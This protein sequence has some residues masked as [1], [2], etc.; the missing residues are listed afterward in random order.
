MKQLILMALAASLLVACSKTESATDGDESTGIIRAT[1]AIEG[2]TSRALA[3]MDEVLRNITFVRHDDPDTDK[4]THFDFTAT[5]AISGVRAAGGAI[6]FSPSQQYDKAGDRTAYLVGC[7]PA[8]NLSGGVMSWTI[9]GATDILLTD[10]WNAGRHSLTR[11]TGMTFRHILARI[12]VVCKAESG[13]ALSVVHAMWGDIEYIK[14]AGVQSA[15]TYTYA[16]HTLD[17]AGTPIDFA[18]L[19]GDA[20][21]EAFAPLPIPAKGSTAVTASAMLPPVATTALTFKVK[22]ALKT[23]K[24]IALALS[25]N[26]APS[27]VHRVELTF[28]ANGRDIDVSTSTIEQW[29]PGGTGGN[30]IID[31]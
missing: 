26:F 10:V 29:T 4:T 9:D 22:N 31:K 8:G 19:R 25:S 11:T 5:P 23:E 18:L 12:E 30:D 2:V 24:T 6:T 20:Y 17:T 13:S 15:M 27:Q 7:H 28:K 1:A 3:G 16:T 14:L 21:A